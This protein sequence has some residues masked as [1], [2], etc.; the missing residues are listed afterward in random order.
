MVTIGGAESAPR[1][2]EDILKAVGIRVKQ[3]ARDL[4]RLAL[5]CLKVTV[6]RLSFLLFSFA[7]EVAMKIFHSHV[8]STFLFAGFSFQSILFYSSKID[9]MELIH[10]Y[11]F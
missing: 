7:K 9:H 3:G 5:F 8:N 11:T 6:G 10:F 4:G 2:K 1:G